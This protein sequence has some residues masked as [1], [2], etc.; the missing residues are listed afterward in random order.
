MGV[1]DQD[2]CIFNIMAADAFV[3][4]GSMASAVMVAI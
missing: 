1:E 3:I 2:P 4:I